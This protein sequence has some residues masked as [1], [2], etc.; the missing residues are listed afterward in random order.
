M[1]F[2][3]YFRGTPLYLCT[4]LRWLGKKKLNLHS[5]TERHGRK[6]KVE[7][8]KNQQKFDEQQQNSLTWKRFVEYSR[9]ICM[10]GFSDPT[11]MQ[12][13]NETLKHIY[14]DP[15]PSTWWWQRQCR[16]SWEKKERKRNLLRR[17]LKI[18]YFRE[19]SRILEI[20]TDSNECLWV[21]SCLPF[22]R[23]DI[24]VAIDYSSLFFLCAIPS[25][26]LRF[27]RCWSFVLGD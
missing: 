7:A 9:Y 5:T 13:F 18:N 14:S 8:W 21:W 17:L 1:S 10:E 26:Q 19:L 20:S 15:L 27:I 11:C 24:G 16:E 4:L 12:Y 2:W 23:L 25:E 6:S 22:T 3:F